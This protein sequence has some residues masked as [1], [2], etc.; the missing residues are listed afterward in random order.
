MEIA[1]LRA[2]IEDKEILKGVNLTLKKGEVHAIMGPNGTGKSTL[3]KVVSGDP[4]YEVLSGSVLLE[5]G[6]KKKD[7]LELDP[8]IRAK[9]GI[10][11]GFQYPVEL[12]GITNEV[13]LHTAFNEI[14][15]YQ[16]VDGLDS[17]DFRKH[18]EKKMKEFNIPKDFMGR[19]VNVG[20]SGGEKKKNEVLQMAVLNP[21]VIF[22]DEMDSGLD[23]DSLRSMGT[24]V[25]GLRTKDNAIVLITHYKRLLDYIKPDFVHV[26]YDGKIVK[27]G[28]MSLVDKIENHG[29]DNLFEK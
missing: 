14:C 26:F 19:Y 4:N 18:L 11:M 15:E 12:P 9:S 16:G 21:K 17:F 10:F 13:F 29:Y 28:D 8:D 20:F 23:V 25:N 2:K 3:A 24:L 1:E 5:E 6:K 7:V 22:L 27:S